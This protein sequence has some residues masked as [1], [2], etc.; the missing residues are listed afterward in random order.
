MANIFIDISNTLIDNANL[1]RLD[2]QI[3]GP[4]YLKEGISHFTEVI[5]ED[6]VQEIAEESEVSNSKKEKK[7]RATL[8]KKKRDVWAVARLSA[9][10]LREFFA[11][12]LVSSLSAP[13]ASAPSSSA[14]SAALIPRLSTL[15]IFVGSARSVV[16]VPHLFAPSASAGSARSA[17]LIFGLSTP[18][19]SVLSISARSAVP[20]PGFS[21]FS[22][23]ALFASALSTSSGFAVPVLGLSTSALPIFGL[24]TFSG[25]VVTPTSGRQKLIKLNQREKKATSEELSPAFT[26]LLPS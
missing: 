24:F 23:S 20:M 1:S 16:P 17:G 9:G 21:T 4:G 5:T 10:C 22:A 15:S 12:G 11:T 25:L 26:P 8:W 3:L 2:L 14:R 18:S 19:T 13:Y 7:K 6:K